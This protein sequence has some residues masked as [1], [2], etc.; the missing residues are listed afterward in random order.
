MTSSVVLFEASPTNTKILRWF[1][2]EIQSH[3]HKPLL[4]VSSIM[5]LSPHRYV[6]STYRK[7]LTLI[8]TSYI[9]R[10]VHGIDFRFEEFADLILRLDYSLRFVPCSGWVWILICLEWYTGVEQMIDLCVTAE[11]LSEVTNGINRL[12]KPTQT[13][14]KNVT[15]FI[16]V[17]FS[18]FLIVLI[19]D[20]MQLMFE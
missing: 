4:N 19:H 10:W 5:V 8:H 12:Q 7:F 17:F 18:C 15:Y 11:G 1:I 13:R 6:V 9:H 2:E 3:I 16:H 14:E 20:E